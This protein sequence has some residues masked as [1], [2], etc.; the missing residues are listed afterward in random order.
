M[1]ESELIERARCP[2]CAL[3][4]ND[5]SGDNLA[6]YSDGHG[7]CYAC[8]YYQKGESTYVAEPK[9]QEEFTPVV[10]TYQGLK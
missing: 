9:I 3:H 6:I 8:H 10:G 5:T 4:G 7:W 1:S 2:R